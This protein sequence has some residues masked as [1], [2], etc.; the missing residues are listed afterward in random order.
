MARQRNAAKLGQT[1]QHVY[2]ACDL[3]LERA[4]AFR[5]LLDPH[6]V[7]TISVRT[8]LTP[9]VVDWRI[10]AATPGAAQLF[11]Y[12]T[13][14]ALEGQWGSLRY[15]LEDLRRAR[16]R[17]TLRALG[18]APVTE[19]YEMRIVQQTGTVER[20]VK[21]VTQRQMSS[22][23]VWVSRYAPANLAAPFQPPPLPETVPEATLHALFGWACL[24]E[25]EALLY[26]RTHAAPQTPIPP[27]GQRLRQARE[28][29]GLSLRQVAATVF[30]TDGHP[31]SRQYLQLIET[32]QRH[33][34]D[35]LL[36]QLAQV[37]ALDPLEVLAHAGRGAALVQAYL[38]GV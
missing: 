23:L 3:S 31:I 30:H 34:T 11:G 26:W 32:E 1:L 28:A 5:T 4:A 38:H 21:H 25:V 13:A 37:L 2:H 7:M 17:A 16:L 35:Q 20:V 9:S 12:E 6:E 33:P 36:W 22:D 8:A 10:V 29:R 27:L 24:A 18:Q 15:V 14:D 19:T